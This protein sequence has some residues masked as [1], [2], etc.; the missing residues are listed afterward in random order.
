MHLV[1]GTGHIERVER[2]VSLPTV[3]GSQS[4]CWAYLLGVSWGETGQGWQGKNGSKRA[5]ACC[6]SPSWC[7]RSAVYGKTTHR[8]VSE[9]ISRS[10][11]AALRWRVDGRTNPTKLLVRL[12]P[13][14][15]LR[16]HYVAMY[17]CPHIVCSVRGRCLFWHAGYGFWY[18]V[19]WKKVEYKYVSGKSD[20]SSGVYY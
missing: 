2:R 19:A 11:R 20:R 6:I 9:Q 16:A 18:T 4:F 17:M 8:K 1:Y 15:T 10:V 12:C 7:A 5:G 3:Q 13:G 14:Q